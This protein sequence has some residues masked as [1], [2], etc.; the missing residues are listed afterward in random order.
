MLHFIGIIVLDS[1][2]KDEKMTK[3][4]VFNYSIIFL[5]ILLISIKYTKKKKLI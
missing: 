4:Q 1:T 2:I 5:I 3:K